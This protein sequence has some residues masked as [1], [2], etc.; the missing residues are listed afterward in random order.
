MRKAHSGKDPINL[1]V[2]TNHPQHYTKD[3]EIAQRAHLL[4]VMN[5]FPVKPLPRPDA[6][7]A[8]HQAA[9]L[10]GNIPQELATDFRQ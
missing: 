1:L 9:N 7:A 10:Y 3:E 5:G 8:L 4:T 2:F 6:L